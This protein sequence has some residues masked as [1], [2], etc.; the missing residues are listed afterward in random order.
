MIVAVHHVAHGLVEPA[1]D[2][3]AQPAGGIGV[4]RIG[5]DDPAGVTAKT[6]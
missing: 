3:G 1:G 6:E 5:G 4:D 2:L